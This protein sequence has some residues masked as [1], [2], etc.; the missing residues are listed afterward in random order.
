MGKR[1]AVCILVAFVLA[2]SETVLGSPATPA[3]IAEVLAALDQG[4]VQGAADLANLGL[5]DE[6]VSASQRGSLLLYRGLARELLGE[7]DSALEDFTRAINT[8]AL[9]PDEREQTLLQRGFLRDSL[10]RLN[11]AIGDYSS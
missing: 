4:N 8:N 1:A 7:S 9:R 2:G 11:E 5:R 6:G 10:G 3:L